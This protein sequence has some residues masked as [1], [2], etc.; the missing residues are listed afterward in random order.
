VIPVGE[1]II[2]QNATVEVT[3]EYNFMQVPLVVS[4]LDDQFEPR[5]TTSD[6]IGDYGET[7][8]SIPMVTKTGDEGKMF[9]AI[10]HYF[11]DG[12]WT[13]MD[14]GGYMAF[15]LEGGAVD[16]STPEGFEIPGGFDLSNIDMDQIASTLNDTFQRGLDLLSDVEIPE[17]L[18]DIEETI[19]EKTGIP[20]FPVE[21]ILV[22][23]TALGY[24]LRK[25]N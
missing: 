18:E 8:Y 7:V 5:G 19:K 24:A 16:Q 4:I 2:G 1:V 10:A 3:V 17:E 15:T 9:Y 21:A 13:Y 25:R 22:G 20:G 23:F 14:P 11:I 12:N 6:E